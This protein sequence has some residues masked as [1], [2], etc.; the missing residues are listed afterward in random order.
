MESLTVDVNLLLT[1]GLI[2]LDSVELRL[3][4]AVV[5]LS[6]P[7]V[8][9]MCVLWELDRQ[10]RAVAPVPVSPA[11]D[12]STTAL[13]VGPTVALGPRY[14]VELLDSAVASELAPLLLE[15]QEGLAAGHSP[16]RILH[17]VNGTYFMKDKNGKKIGIFK[18]TDEEF[19]APEDDSSSFGLLPGE[20][21]VR[22]AAAFRVA[23]EHETPSYINVPPTGLVRIASP[24]STFAPDAPFDAAPVVKTGSLQTFVD[25]DGDSEEFG[26]SRFSVDDVH[27]IG[28]LDVQI[29][30]CDRNAENL[31]VQERDDGTVSLV[32]IDHG[33]SMPGGLSLGYGRFEWLNFEASSKPF[34]PETLAYIEAIDVERIIA[35]L[36]QDLNIRAECLDAVR[37]A[38]TFLKRAAARGWTL[39]EIG[40]AVCRRNADEPSRL[41]QLYQSAHSD[42]TSLEHKIDE[43]FAS[44]ASTSP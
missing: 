36:R 25:A 20:A 14:A 43:F 24:C 22:E 16:E 41:E 35:M 30:N 39:R 7:H 23:R 13:S 38:N 29:L 33:F 11:D 3:G 31:L 44:K 34:S 27:R 28:V 18:P 37:A 15:V 42:R 6:A 40:E 17:G 5:R 4:K 10:A 2:A 26:S 12:A 21:A 32:P 19:H 1:P 9:L 8:T